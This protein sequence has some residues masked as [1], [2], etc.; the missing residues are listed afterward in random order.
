[1]CIGECGSAILNETCRLA[2]TA[3]SSSQGPSN[4]L[5]SVKGL[6]VVLVCVL[7]GWVWGLVERGIAYKGEPLLEFNAPDA[8]DHVSTRSIL[9]PL[10]R[11]PEPVTVARV[12]QVTCRHS[13]PIC[14][15]HGHCIAAERQEELASWHAWPL[16]A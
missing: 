8:V 12:S 3:M 9:R 13:N 6:Q 5:L 14:L 4:S 7:G 11:V 16:A 2:T 10:R 1:V 15:R